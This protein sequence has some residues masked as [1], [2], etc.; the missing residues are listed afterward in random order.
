MNIGPTR[1][2][3]LFAQLGLIGLHFFQYVHI[4]KLYVRPNRPNVQFCNVHILKKVLGP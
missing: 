1:K 2:N 3:A 4:T